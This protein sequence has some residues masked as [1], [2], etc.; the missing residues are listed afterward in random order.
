MLNLEKH[1]TTITI[2]CSDCNPGILECEAELFNPHR[3][4]YLLRFPLG[5]IAS[6]ENSSTDPNTTEL[7]SIIKKIKRAKIY[8]ITHTECKFLNLENTIKPSITNMPKN[9]LNIYELVCSNYI[10]LVNH[11]TSIHGDNS[12][13][14]IKTYIFDDK[15]HRLYQQ[16]LIIPPKFIN[17]NLRNSAGKITE[18]R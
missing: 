13:F 18:Y 7:I 14:M 4:D 1:M 5:M 17:V 3:V 8:L 2:L 10:H 12:N 9:S 15:D 11:I 6:L 16:E